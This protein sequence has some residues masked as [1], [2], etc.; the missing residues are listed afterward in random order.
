MP[1]RTV[2]PSRTCA[3]LKSRS[4]TWRSARRRASARVMNGFLAGRG[5]G[6]RGWGRLDGFAL[7]WAVERWWSWV[8]GFIA[9]EVGAEQGFEELAV[10]G[11]FQVKEFVDDDV[12]AEC[13]RL[14]ED[15]G[16][17]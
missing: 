13:R 9:G 14:R 6:R 11:D 8:D 3:P 15:F 7:G 2:A 17:E 16:A 12:F 4:R 10:V 1:R 5:F